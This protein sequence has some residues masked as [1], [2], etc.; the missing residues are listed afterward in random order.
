MIKAPNGALIPFTEEDQDKLRSIKSGVAVRCNIARARN[1]QFLKKFFCLVRLAFDMWTESVPSMQYKGRDVLPNIERFRKDL[2]IMAG[3]Y[4]ATYNI[5][6]DVR[7]EAKSI[8]FANMEEETFEALYSSFID[9]V[10]RKVLDRPD[11]TEDRLRRMVD[12]VMS[13]S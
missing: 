11:L 5:R 4:D 1:P 10:L 6:G 12:Q 7:L 9:V 13:Y 3:Y 2:T 8:S